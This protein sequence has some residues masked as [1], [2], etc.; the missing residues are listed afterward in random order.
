MNEQTSYLELTV[1]SGILQDPALSAFR[2]Y[3]CY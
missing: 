2:A 1:L 3:P